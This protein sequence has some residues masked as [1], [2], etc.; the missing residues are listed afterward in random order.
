LKQLRFKALLFLTKES[1]FRPE[2]ACARV[3]YTPIYTSIWRFYGKSYLFAMPL[4]RSTLIPL[5]YHPMFVV[6]FAKKI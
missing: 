1:C 4:K 3:N 5:E 2:T 6:H